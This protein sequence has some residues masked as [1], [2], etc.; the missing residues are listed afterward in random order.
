MD[1]DEWTRWSNVDVFTVSINEWLNPLFQ[2]DRDVVG[3]HD[4]D[5]DDAESRETE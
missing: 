5:D 2:D 4:D 1:L 3:A